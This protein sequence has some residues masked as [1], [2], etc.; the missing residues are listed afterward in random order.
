VLKYK[1]K[2]TPRA[3]QLD[4]LEAGW[5]EPSFAYLMGRGT[6]KTKVALDNA[7]ILY[8]Q[9]KIDALLVIAPNEIHNRWIT[10]QIPL[11]LPDRININTFIWPLS[12]K[13]DPF[14]KEGFTVLSMNIEALQYSK[15]KDFSRKFCRAHRIMVVVDESTRIKTP[16]IKRTRNVIYLNKISLY[17]RILTGNE[18]TNSPFDIY[19]PFKFLYP[20]FWNCNYTQFKE[21]YGEWLKQYAKTKRCKNETPCSECKRTIRPLVVRF[22]NSKMREWV[23]SFKCPDC[24]KKIKSANPKVT[25]EAKRIKNA[26][27]LY[28]FPVLKNYKNMPELRSKIAK[29]AFRVRKRDCLDLP[30]KIYDPI[31]AKLN[32]EQEKIYQE[33][34]EKFLVEYEGHELTV[35]NKL[36][37]G[38]RFQQIV[39]GFFPT[40]E[41]EL[42]FIGSPKMDRLLYDLE[43]NDNDA[44]IIWAVFVAEIEYIAI[45]LQRNFPKDRTAVLYGGT[46]KKD[47]QQII[48]DFQEGRIRF[49]VANPEVGGVGLNFQRSNLHYYY[50]N[51]HKPEPRWQSEDRSHRDGQHWPVVYKDIFIR[52]TV[53]DNIKKSLERKVALAEFFKDKTIKEMI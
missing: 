8:E 43:D 38:I 32:K 42:I 29:Y 3:H 53:D 27:G 25:A 20:S 22:Y 11:H 44:I 51:S 39:G 35:L 5:S 52:G 6:G 14:K 10:E 16:G 47:R 31:Y 50:S 46:K 30:E 36:S 19:A 48:D 28:E 17:R 13:E 7:A 45:T 4:A 40:D 9:D 2:T 37:I 34:K 12:K 23:V 1:F 18:V 33:L 21:H 15:G 41:E 49:L 24:G 26:R